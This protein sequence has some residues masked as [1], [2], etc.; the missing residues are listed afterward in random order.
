MGAG[1][2]IYMGQLDKPDVEVSGHRAA[3]HCNEC[4]TDYWTSIND[5]N[6]CPECGSLDFEVGEGSHG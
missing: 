2:Y 5:S 4:G 6:D 3:L 1:V